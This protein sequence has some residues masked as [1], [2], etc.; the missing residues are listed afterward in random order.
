MKKAAKFLSLTGLCAGIL[1]ASWTSPSVAATS[2]YV[3]D[4]NK[5][6]EKTN[7]L[8]HDA[9]HHVVHKKKVK[10]VKTYSSR[11][12]KHNSRAPRHSHTYHSHFHRAHSRNR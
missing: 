11:H 5:H 12:I 9:G 7:V 3:V 2:T 6:T 8:A 4:V 10:V 1:V